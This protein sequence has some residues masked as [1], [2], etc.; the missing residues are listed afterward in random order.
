MEDKNC[1]RCKM[2]G[3]KVKPITMESHLGSQA[4]QRWEDSQ[5]RFCKTPTCEVVYFQATQRFLVEDIRTQVYQ[6]SRAEKRLVC[7]CFQHSVRDIR[8]EIASTG[9]TQVYEEISKQCKE[10]RDECPKKNPQGSCCL[11]NVKAVINSAMAD[12]DVV[13]EEGPKMDDCGSCCGNEATPIAEEKVIEG[14]AKVASRLAIVAAFFSSSCC[15]LPLLFVLFG[16]SGLGLSAILEGFR[17]PMLVLAALF[18]SLSFYFIYIRSRPCARSG[19]FSKMNKVSFWGSVIAVLIFAFY[20]TFLIDLLR[21]SRADAQT[22]DVQTETKIEVHH[23]RIEGMTC[24]GCSTTLSV[25]LSKVP[26]VKS[27]KVSFP[28]KRASV[29]LSA[30]FDDALIIVAAKDAGYIATRVQ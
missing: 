18:L 29:E 11:G 24:E 3:R 14:E 12:Y 5:A 8:D 22:V 7:Y 6:K 26:G 16:G 1:P 30:S 21:V 15:W 23:F 10:G 25:I 9:A 4:L 17:T 2:T 19:K 28:D 13:N 27:V 20:P